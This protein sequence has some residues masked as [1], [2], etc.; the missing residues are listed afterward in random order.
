M[1]KQKKFKPYGE[2]TYAITRTR[3][4]RR[5]AGSRAL[6]RKHGSPKRQSRFPMLSGDGGQKSYPMNLSSSSKFVDIDT[7]FHSSS[8]LRMRAGRPPLATRY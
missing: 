1:N 5:F 4:L 3:S 8:L 2:R 6:K 7:L